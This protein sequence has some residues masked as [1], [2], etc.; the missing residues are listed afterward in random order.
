MCNVDKRCTENVCGNN[1]AINGN[2]CGFCA[3]GGASPGGVDG[4][5]FGGPIGFCGMG[6]GFPSRFAARE[7]MNCFPSQVKSVG[8]SDWED[9]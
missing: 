5:L 7:E 8:A 1:D 2:E 9:V 6:G 4:T 3:C